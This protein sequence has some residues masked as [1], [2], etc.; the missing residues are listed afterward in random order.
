[1]TAIALHAA[2]DHEFLALAPELPIILNATDAGTTEGLPF[3]QSDQNTMAPTLNL[4]GIYERG[5]QQ[6]KPIN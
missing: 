3:R 4:A 5:V 6:I 2:S 1:L